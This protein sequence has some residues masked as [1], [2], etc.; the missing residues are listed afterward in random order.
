LDKNA[1]KNQ[2]FHRWLDWTKMPIKTRTFTGHDV[3]PTSPKKMSD[4]HRKTYLA[5]DCLNVH[6]LNKMVWRF[7]TR[8]KPFLAWIKF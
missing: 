6:V 8:N 7:I 2:K 5:F 4:V 3:D 1:D